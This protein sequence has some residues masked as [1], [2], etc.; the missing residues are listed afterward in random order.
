MRF[1]TL[2]VGAALALSALSGCAS[3]QS[4]SGTVAPVGGAAFAP[5][6]TVQV[7]LMDAAGA[8]VATKS[9]PV[10]GQSE[11]IPFSINAADAPN[12]NGRYELRARVVSRTGQVLYQSAQGMQVTM[13]PSGTINV[14]VQPAGR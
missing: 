6:A 10:D 2:L 11:A 8:V 4:F 1:N 14:T 3:T 7:M 13:P 12:A 5:D 9:V